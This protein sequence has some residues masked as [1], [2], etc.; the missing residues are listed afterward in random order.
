MAQED[1]T[2]VDP[3]TTDTTTLVRVTDNRR[4]ALRSRE[5]GPN[6]PDDPVNGQWW[7]EG[8][9]TS[10]LLKLHQ[11]V[12]T[13]WA[14]VF[15]IDV[16]NRR[17]RKMLDADQDTYAA[18]TGTDGE[19][20][21]WVE[22]TLAYVLGANGLRYGS[23]ASVMAVDASAKTTGIRLPSGT[24]AQRPTPAAGM[25]RYNTT[26]ARVEQTVLVD[27]AWVW[28]NVPLTSEVEVL[29]GAEQ[30][31]VP[32]ATW[33]EFTGIPAKT[34]M[35]IVT[36][37]SI[38]GSVRP[39]IRAGQTV[40]PTTFYYVL[41]LGDSGGYESTGYTNVGSYSVY[42]GGRSYTVA[43]SS[44]A[45]DGLYVGGWISALYPNHSLGS[46]SVTLWRVG[47]N[48]WMLESDVLS[49]G[50][51]TKTM[52]SPLDRLRIGAS[53]YNET[54]AVGTPLQGRTRQVTANAVSLLYA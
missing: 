1:F 24:T 2:R 51:S 20:G 18:P 37:D 17:I 26:T 8:T 4:E 50:T 40:W 21:I 10:P 42:S 34:R 19:V 32:Y 48:R 36:L 41:Q 54:S 7:V 53:P 22:G 5:L 15:V 16:A 27:G 28:Q 9:D 38:S 23:G 46:H 13:G 35:I 52:S 11:R 39:A 31:N 14:L 49:N 29:N 47:G 30:T 6:P 45:N 44:F 33:I 3:L 25:M 43:L 12:S